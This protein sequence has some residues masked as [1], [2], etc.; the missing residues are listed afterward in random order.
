MNYLL[1]FPVFFPIVASI[2]SSFFKGHDRAR[3]LYSALIVTFELAVICV[4][5]V[6]AP[7]SEIRLN[8]Y[9]GLGLGFRFDGIRMVLGTV[10][11]LMWCSTSIFCCEY[12]RSYR[13]R[14]R[15]VFFWLFTLGAI[16]GVFLASDLFTLF[17][18][19]EIMSFTSYTWV[20]HDET[21]EALRAAQTY[22]AIAVVGGLVALM[23][24]FLLCN[25]AGTLDISIL[26]KSVADMDRGRLYAASVCLLFGFGAKAGMFPLHIWLPKAH[27]VAPAPASALLSGILTKSGILGT[28][29]IC[30]YLM[31]GDLPW[32]TLILTLGCVTMLL[33][34]VLAVFSVDL[35]RTLACSSVSQIGFILIGAGM[36]CMLGEEGG[37]AV[38]GTIAHM[39]N[40]S[41]FKLVL[42]SAAGVVYMNLHKLGLNDVRGFGHKKP[43][44][45]IIFLLAAAGIAGIPGLSGYVSKTLL[46]E[47]IVEGIAE[48]GS[49]WLRVVEWVFLFSGG[50]TLAYMTKLFVCLFIDTPAKDQHKPDGKYIHLSSMLA[51]GVPAVVFPLF[52]IRTGLF[53]RVTDLCR[54]FFL[55]E[56]M[57]YAEYFSLE[58]L[59]GSAISILI[60]VVVYF[61]FILPALTKKTTDGREYLDRLPKWLD[62]EDSVYRPLIK[63]LTI[64]GGWIGH[65]FG[66]WTDLDANYPIFKAIMFLG[67][68]IARFF[69][70]F[71]DAIVSLLRIS[72]F[73]DLRIPSEDDKHQAHSVTGMILNDAERILN[74]TSHRKKKSKI[75]WEKRIL[76]I[77]ERTER[78]ERMVVRGMSFSL[79]MACFGLCAALIYLLIRFL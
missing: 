42:F 62:L 22:L 60:G 23:G 39:L 24:L 35:K 33:G 75:D 25:H 17:I 31:R 19:F 65:I 8:G 59:K 20:A 63:G 6:I 7:E 36:C 38:R 12:M 52:G 9:F 73:R 46:H 64:G 11:A 1:F 40:H 78:T 13:D 3:D 56:T 71:T 32:A 66:V 43:F 54:N 50:L 58:S 55:V 79:L 27:P 15:F 53:D 26:Q 18:F 69:G 47:S 76:S 57:H 5:I 30:V 48:T 44:L 67:T 49:V 74:V 28:L 10:A 14:R 72:F 16:E 70:T 45:L 61:G 2:V 68:L 51:I 41:M 4:M 77:R 29:V 34:A 21:P 37:L